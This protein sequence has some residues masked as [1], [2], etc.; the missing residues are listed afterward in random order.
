MSRTFLNLFKHNTQFHSKHRCEQEEENEEM[1]G[2]EQEQEG[3]LQRLRRAGG[4]RMVFPE[5]A[6]HV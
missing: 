2:D 6:G 3:L 4:V 1:E 5:H